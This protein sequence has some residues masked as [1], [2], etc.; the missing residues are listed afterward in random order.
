M[1][2][3][4]MCI[5]NMHSEGRWPGAMCYPLHN[6]DHWTIQLPFVLSFPPHCTPCKFFTLNHFCFLSDTIAMQYMISTPGSTFMACYPS[7]HP[8]T[9]YT[10][11]IDP[12]LESYVANTIIN[13]L[14]EDYSGQTDDVSPSTHLYWILLMLHY[15]VCNRIDTTGEGRSNHHQKWFKNDQ[16]KRI[17]GEAS[18]PK[19]PYGHGLPQ[20]LSNRWD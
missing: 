13:Q 6:S 12:P 4:W 19:F 17:F 11:A 9:V 1:W 7:L 10:L 14:Q 18:H 3:R 20:L 8:L 15:T 5:L 16:T 2:Q